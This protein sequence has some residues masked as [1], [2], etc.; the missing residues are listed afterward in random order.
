M[1]IVTVLAEAKS[2]IRAASY[3]QERRLV[4]DLM[5]FLRDIAIC[6]QN[7]MGKEQKATVIEA[8]ESSVYWYAYLF[9]RQDILVILDGTK[10]A[11]NNNE[12]LKV[13]S[14][15]AGEIVVEIIRYL[16]KSFNAQYIGQILSAWQE[17]PFWRNGPP[18]LEEFNLS[19]SDKDPL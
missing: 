5:E 9:R 16:K 18:Q 17:N 19:A 3:G 1:R 12:A 11:R 13:I 7:D 15:L 6:Q 4:Q 10:Y 14:A 8:V 2:T